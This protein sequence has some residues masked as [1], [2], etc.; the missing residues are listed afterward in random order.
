MNQ[1]TT[2]H[3]LVSQKNGVATLTMNRPKSLNALSMDMRH[4]MFEAVD[5][6]EHDPSVRCVVLRGAGGTFMAGGDI[7][8]FAE[9][10]DKPSSQRAAYFERRVHNLS[11]MLISLQRMNKPVIASVEGAAAG[12]GMSLMMACDLA[13]AT[14]DSVY[15]FAYSAIGASPDGSGSYYLPRLVGTRR[16]LEL[17]L[18]ADKIDAQTA[19]Q[20]GLVNFLV[21]PAEIETETEKL[22]KRLANSATQSLA[23]I[24]KLMHSSHTNSLETQL[25][26]EA[27]YF[28][29]C[30]ATQDWV[31]GVSAF[32][33]KRKPEF[34]GN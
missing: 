7:K 16:A 5:Q 31:E 2:D 33:E 9:H 25:A 10:T 22:S 29:K 17:S 27:E 23:A 14:T 1:Q 20:Y 6:I 19:H 30:A 34:K 8:N 12:I 18:L 3:L 11:P 24:K 4:A 13:I 26:M 32:N 15:R 21:D 28:G